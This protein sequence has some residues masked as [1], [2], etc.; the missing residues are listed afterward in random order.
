MNAANPLKDIKYK[1]IFTDHNEIALEQIKD[2]L[3]AG[4][5]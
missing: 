2:R 1:F 3:H 4:R 5:T